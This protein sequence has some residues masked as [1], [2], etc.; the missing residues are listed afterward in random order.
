MEEKQRR[1]LERGRTGPEY[2]AEVM[3]LRDLV[4][5]RI[6][7]LVGAEAAQVALTC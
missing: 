5:A 6:A 7:A 2:F 3:R 4:R 1:D